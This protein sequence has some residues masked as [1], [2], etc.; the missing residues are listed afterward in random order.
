MSYHFF[1]LFVTV[2]SLYEFNVMNVLRH[3]L[4]LCLWLRCFFKIALLY[5]TTVANF[6]A[7]F[8]LKILTTP[9]YVVYRSSYLEEQH[10]LLSQH[11][12]PTQ[13]VLVQCISLG[14]R[15]RV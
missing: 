5:W 11:S 7:M 2:Y 15:E 9:G 3:N 1:C 13:S 4:F 12:T 14:D 8:L 6:V 10:I